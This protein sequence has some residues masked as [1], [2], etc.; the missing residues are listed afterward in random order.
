MKSQQKIVKIKALPDLNAEKMAG[1]EAGAGDVVNRPAKT[2]ETNIKER[3]NTYKDYC[4]NLLVTTKNSISVID[5]TC[6]QTA[7]SNAAGDVVLIQNVN[8]SPDIL[9]S[10]IVDGLDT[11]SVAV[12]TGYAIWLIYNPITDVVGGLFSLSY[13][14][15]TLPSGFTFKRLISFVNVDSFRFIEFQQ[16]GNMYFYTDMASLQILTSGTSKTLATVNIGRFAGSNNLM[17]EGWFF[18]N[19][20]GTLGATSNNFGLFVRPGYTGLTWVEKEVIARN[21]ITAGTLED[22]IGEQFDCLLDSQSFE[23]RLTNVSWVALSA[24]IWIYGG[25]LNI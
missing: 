6:D 8:V 7:I 1:D 13:T 15:P 21:R 23:Y 9:S 5:I 16:A 17:T 2:I 18:G 22:T 12:N 14:S 24:N 20:T 19:L 25:I 11:G 4:N 3:W 10:G